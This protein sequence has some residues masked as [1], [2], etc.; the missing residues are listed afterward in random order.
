MLNGMAPAGGAIVSLS[1][2]NAAGSVPPNVTAPAGANSIGFTVTTGVVSGPTPV[3]ITA[4][5]GGVTASA[6]L[7]VITQGI[8]SV[9]LS[10]AQVRGGALLTGN[11]VNLAGAAPAGGAVISL[12]SSNPTVASV[13]SNV[14]VAAGGFTSPP[15]TI[16]TS[17]VTTP[18]SVTITGTYGGADAT[19]TFIVNPLFPQSVILN[20]W[21]AAG[22][23]V[24]TNNFVR[25]DSPAPAGGITV[26]LSSSNPVLAGVPPT[27]QVLAGN[28]D[29]AKFSITTDFVTATTPVTI[30]ASYGGVTRSAVV[31]VTPTAVNSVLLNPTTIGGGGSTASNKVGLDGP[32]PPGGVVVALSSS[33]AAAAQ[34]PAS[35]TISAGNAQSPAFTITTSPVAST[36]PVTISA[37]YAGVTR[38][39]ILTVEAIGVASI[40]VNPANIAGG[41]SANGSVTLNSPAPAGG[42]TVTLVSSDPGAAQTPP[43]VTVPASATTSPTFTITTSSVPAQTSVTITAS[44]GGSSKSATLVVGQTALLSMSISRSSVAG[45]SSFGSNTVTLNGAAPAGGAGVTLSSSNSSV[46][47]VPAAVIVPQGAATSPPFDIST[48]PVATST[49]V[50][51]S[52]IFGGVTRTFVL[53]VLPVQ[54]QSVALNPVATGGGNTTTNNTIVL[55]GA[56]PAG[57]S[58]VTLASSNPSLAS[59][60]A[61]VTVPAGGTT[62]AKFNILTSAVSASTNVT[63]S[64]AYAG[65]TASRVLTLQP[66]ALLSVVLG[67]ANVVGGNPTTS[68]KCGLNTVAPPGGITVSL[69][70]S[71]PALAAVP[72]SVTITPGTTNRPDFPITTAGVAAPTPV[73]ISAS[74]S[75]VTKTAVLTVNPAALTSIGL[76]PNVVTGGAST[77]ANDVGLTGFA[78]PSGAVISLSSSNPAVASVPASI[79][80][81]EGTRTAT[82]PISTTA[83][84][85]PQLVTITATYN[86]VTR[87]ATL[88]VN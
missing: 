69:S 13:P 20:P 35:V 27:V 62:S 9:T 7:T 86:G 47:S 64:A 61:S 43:S 74:Y 88:T 15:F 60:P 46:L 22:G 18:T 82:F 37:T 51:I 55:N 42:L 80:I 71:N 4:S 77:T 78:P 3:T 26:A 72:P 16:T 44:L 83:P 57:G 40:T 75:G 79:T 54:V 48:T 1:S 19:A 39:G 41:S 68:N 30:S 70:S 49:P 53:T 66:P 45:G 8:S 12:S 87:T 67:P 2:S 14:T 65:S 32:A 73:T 76:S 28:V 59:V 34:T 52:A 36:T 11:T 17:A 85:V 58:V 38:T 56:A 81:I 10:A 21:T 25:L 5:L 33:N 23:R 31:T 50:T 6:A 84:S 29:S 24:T 63:I